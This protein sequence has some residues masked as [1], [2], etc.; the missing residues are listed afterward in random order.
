ML[1]KVGRGGY[2]VYL[3]A[4][5][6][7]CQSLNDCFLLW[8]TLKTSIWSQGDACYLFH[9]HFSIKIGPEIAKKDK[10]TTVWHL[11]SLTDLNLGEINLFDKNVDELCD[12]P[13]V[14]TPWKRFLR[15]VFFLSFR[16]WC[17]NFL[18]FTLTS[19]SA[20]WK[21]QFCRY[22]LWSTWLTCACF[23]EE[24]EWDASLYS[25]SSLTSRRKYL[26]KEKFLCQDS[27]EENVAR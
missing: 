13:P 1:T 21:R 14:T 8:R 4:F 7:N 27:P 23:D 9:M 17:H 22:Q 24:L 25:L 15:F 5:F 26:Q 10:E 6:W 19:Y 20:N 12:H 18:E 3:M 16:W 11:N 2:Q